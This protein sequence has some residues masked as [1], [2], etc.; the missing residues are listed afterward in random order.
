MVN[1]IFVNMPV[2]DLALSMDFFAKLGFTF[3]AQLTDENAACMVIGDNIFAMLLTEEFFQTF[4]TKEIANTQETTEAL[5]ALS[6]ESP[7]EVDE[8]IEQALLAGGSESR[9]V[10]DQGFMYSRGFEDLDGHLWEVFY[11]DEKAA[12]ERMK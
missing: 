1:K 3:N 8:R 10:Q 6:V 7:E 2:K 4:T 5:L 9:E 12:A 11:M